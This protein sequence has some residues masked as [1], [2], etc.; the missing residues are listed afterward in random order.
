MYSKT[1]LPGTISA[2]LHH[3]FQFLEFCSSK[4]GSITPTKDAS[5]IP[6]RVPNK[7]DIK[8]SA[9]D[10]LTLPPNITSEQFHDFVYRAREIV[11]HENVEIISESS[12]LHKEYYTD[13]SKVHDMHNIVDKEY[14]VA[15]ATVSPRKVPEVQ[16]IMRLCN[17][18]LIPV[19][20]VSIGRK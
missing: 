14:F 2:A 15:S 19:W 3:Q 18:V 12:Q 16:D 7:S 8:R 9:Q 13:P 10:P 20:P 11:G 1:T 6:L 17:E 5:S 4:M